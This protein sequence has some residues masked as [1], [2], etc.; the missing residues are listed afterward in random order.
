MFYTEYRKNIITKMRYKNIKQLYK[1]INDDTLSYDEKIKLQKHF[2]RY[3]KLY[4]KNNVCDYDTMIDLMKENILNIIGLE[5]DPL[6]Q[7]ID[8][9][10][11]IEYYNTQYEP[12]INKLPSSG[13]N[14]ICLDIRKKN[15][16]IS[17]PVGLSY[18]N[19]ER[20]KTFDAIDEYNN[21]YCIKFVNE[22]GGSQDN[23]IK[24]VEQFLRYSD[25]YDKEDINFI[26][27]LS[28]DYIYSFYKSMKKKYKNNDNIELIYL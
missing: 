15:I 24:D 18:R 19:G 28:G 11:Q 6:R 27:I 21:L 2:S 3:E 5:K 22:S 9:K 13:K 25:V 12:P 10:L 7:S 1:N 8:E 20:T 17:S 16:K 23:Q 26:Y 4:K 14:S